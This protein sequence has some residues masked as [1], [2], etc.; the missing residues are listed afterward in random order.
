M[1]RSPPPALNR[2]GSSDGSSCPPFLS[3]RHRSRYR[4]RIHHDT[5]I[6]K[7]VMQESGEAEQEKGGS[8][9]KVHGKRGKLMT[10]RIR[11]APGAREGYERPRIRVRTSTTAMGRYAQPNTTVDR[12]LS[13]AGLG[14]A[15]DCL[16]SLDSEYPGASEKLESRVEGWKLEREGVTRRASG[17]SVWHGHSERIWTFG[18]SDGGEMVGDGFA[19]RCGGTVYVFHRAFDGLLQ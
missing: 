16:K 9:G 1:H 3:P 5:T 12:R 17:G 13:G 15:A 19:T 7:R 2:I 4:P 11:N 8:L 6:H 10:R 14:V 18:G